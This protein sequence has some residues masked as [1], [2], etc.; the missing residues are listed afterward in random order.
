[1]SCNV[2]NDQ[3]GCAVSVWNLYRYAMPFK[4]GCM[5]G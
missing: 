4:S 5:P 2:L 1:M 3:S